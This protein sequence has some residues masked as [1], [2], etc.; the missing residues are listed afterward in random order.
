M[1]L[2]CVPLKVHKK[3]H[4]RVVI[5]IVLRVAAVRVGVV[6]N[7]TAKADPYTTAN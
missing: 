1:A 5:A 7:A 4:I 6:V 2:A 3:D